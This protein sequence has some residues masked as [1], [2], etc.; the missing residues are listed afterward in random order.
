MPDNTDYDPVADSI[1]LIEA[2]IAKWQTALE[3]LREVQAMRAQSGVAAG[4]VRTAREVSF[5]HDAFFG[6]TLG[7][8][9]RKYLAATKKTA[10]TS[11]LAEALVAGGWKTA[12]KNI[13][14]TIRAILSRNSD[15]VKIN[16]EFGLAE[17]YPGRKA[18]TKRRSAVSSSEE[19]S[20]DE[21]SS[22]EEE[23]SSE[24]EE[25]S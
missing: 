7:D 17:W 3:S 13:P 23:S 6:M 19:S 18:A 16:G 5:S 9:A 1:V 14:E 20:E 4:T 12:A 15:F 10:A 11:A 24:S 25:E 8:A 2:Q 21:T 22:S